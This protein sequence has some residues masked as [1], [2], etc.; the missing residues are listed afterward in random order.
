MVEF[1]RISLVT[2]GH[3]ADERLIREYVVPGLDRMQ[4]V[5]GCEGVR[6][7]RFGRVPDATRSEVKLGIHGDYETVIEQERERWDRLEADGLIESWSRAGEPFPEQPEAVQSF[8]AR[9]YVLASNMAAE[10]FDEFDV[11][12]DLIEEVPSDDRR[13]WGLWTVFH[14]LA[15]DMGYGAEEEVEAYTLLLRD[16]LVALTELRDH[17]YVRDEIADLRRELDDLEARV[18]D[19][20]AQG[21]FDYYSEPGE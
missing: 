10:Y 6:F 11:Q 8:M 1:E 14:V 5:D 3:E 20:E 21:G 19:L 15:N 9:T 12:P 18:D 17:E 16:R 2:S 7:T 4:A 13:S